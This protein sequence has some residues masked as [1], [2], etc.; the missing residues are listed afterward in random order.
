MWSAKFSQGLSW[1][2][3]NSIQQDCHFPRSFWDP[4]ATSV[5][6]LW[7][8]SSKVTLAEEDKCYRWH[9]GYICESPYPTW[10]EVLWRMVRLTQPLDPLRTIVVPLWALFRHGFPA[11][12]SL[13][14]LFSF[15]Q[16]PVFLSAGWF[17]SLPL[18]DAS[19]SHSSGHSL[20]PVRSSEAGLPLLWPMLPQ[21]NLS[22][23]SSES[24]CHLVRS[25]TGKPRI[26]SLRVGILTWQSLPCPPLDPH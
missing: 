9:C 20:P 16:K 12:S 15:L 18:L 14:L 13:H 5:L 4:P 11:L 24:W 17:L 19:P 10:K 6:A 3:W 2:T 26:K 22:A 21:T 23:P 7:D 8:L 25:G 1:A